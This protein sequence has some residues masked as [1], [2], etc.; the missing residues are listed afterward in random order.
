MSI[1]R[2]VTDFDHNRQANSIEDMPKKMGPQRPGFAEAC[3][4]GSSDQAQ[5]KDSARENKKFVLFPDSNC[6]KREQ[7]W[8]I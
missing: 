4:D 6:K 3:I 5:P 2:T 1:F 7:G 8:E